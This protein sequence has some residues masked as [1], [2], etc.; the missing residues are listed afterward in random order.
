MIGNL[1]QKRY[2]ILK[3]LG[4]G[5]FGQTYLAQDINLN[6]IRVVKKLQPIY[7]DP[8][9]LQLAK[10][11]FQRESDVLN[12]LEKGHPQ[13]PQLFDRF[14][15]NQE[16]YLVLEYI[17]G[18]TLIAELNQDPMS[19]DQVKQLLMDIL[20]PLSFVHDQNIIHRDIKPAN[21]IRRKSD[22]QICLIDFGAVKQIFTATPNPQ[23]PQNPNPYTVGIGSPGYA[24]KEQAE[25]R[26]TLASDIYALGILGIQALTGS[27]PIQTDPTTSQIIWTKPASV[28]DEF[29]KI[30]NRMIHID[31]TK[32]YQTASELLS[33]LTP[34]QVFL[35]PVPANGQLAKKPNLAVL[36][37]ASILATA[38]GIGTILGI[39][40][41][42]AP[43][44]APPPPINQPGPL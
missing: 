21:L 37:P 31:A 7:T 41:F 1:L 12:M 28:S 27:I 43:K 10:D 20:K 42:F 13:I 44:P 26:P 33:A 14:E 8:G 18:P 40:H 30:L 6:K 25:G 39:Y 4:K 34:T 32:R 24:P 2:K 35:K 11:L 38:L 3:E 9:M 5:A 36:I 23:N 16:F 17:E 22:N 15:E 19:A 29:E